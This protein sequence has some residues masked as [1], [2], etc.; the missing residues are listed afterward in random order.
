[1]RTNSEIVGL[2]QCW[3]CKTKSNTHEADIC[4]EMVRFFLLQGYQQDQIV[5]LTP[6][7][8][9]LMKIAIKLKM[10]IKETTAYVSDLDL[11]EMEEEEAVNTKDTG[12]RHG[13]KLKSIRCATIDNFQGEE[14]DI[15]IISLVRSNKTGNIG[16]LKEEQRVNVLLSRARYGLFLV[17]NSQTLLSSKMGKHVWSP[18]LDMMRSKGQIL[19]GLPSLCQLHPSDE[20]IL[21]CQPSDF[22]K[23]RPNGGCSRPCQYRMECGHACYQG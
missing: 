15:V 10:D 23:N 11:Q 14:S 21:L 1:M 13:E 5:V 3:T 9:Q 19:K 22:R 12:G 18:L 17:G 7:V 20:T 2:I 4:V 6:Y 16:F 8:G